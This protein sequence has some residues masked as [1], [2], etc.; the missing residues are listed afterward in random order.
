MF[1]VQRTFHLLPV[2]DASYVKHQ[3]TLSERQEVG[4]VLENEAA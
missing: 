1:T 2:L 4:R 3:M